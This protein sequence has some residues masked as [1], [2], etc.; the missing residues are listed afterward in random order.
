M[1]TTSD[2]SQK[3]PAQMNASRTGM[4]TMELS[5]RSFSELLLWML[6]LPAE[7]TYASVSV[8]RAPKRRFRSLKA[9]SALASSFSSKSGQKTGLW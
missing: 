4:P 2:S 1:A 3:E 9:L 6:A 8:D 5:S 7:T